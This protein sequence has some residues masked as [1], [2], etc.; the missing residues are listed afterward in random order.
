MENHGCFPGLIPTGLLLMVPAEA[1]QALRVCWNSPFLWWD[2]E[3]LVEFLEASWNRN[4]QEPAGQR[5]P[6]AQTH[7]LVSEQFEPFQAACK[8][9]KNPSKRLY[10]WS[11]RMKPRP[12]PPA[13]G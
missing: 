3:G 8:A 7:R 5:Q 10:V 4:H 2:W 11:E 1:N 6:K 9:P 12:L 13:H